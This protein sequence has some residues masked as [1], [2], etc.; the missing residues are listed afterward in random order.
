MPKRFF[1]DICRGLVTHT[2]SI[3]LIHA[4]RAGRIERD[5]KVKSTVVRK[6]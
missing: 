1:D 2:V 6:I 5:G 3:M 4:H